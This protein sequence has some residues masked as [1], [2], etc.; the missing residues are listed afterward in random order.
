M[1]EEIFTDRSG[2]FRFSQLAPGDY[3]VRVRKSGYVDVERRIDLQ[4]VSSDF[5]FV[6][7]AADKAARS[8]RPS[9][10]VAPLVLDASVPAPARE[11]FERGREMVL[12]G[13]VEQGLPALEKAVV[14]HP[15]F[16]DA[17]LLLGT[18]YMDL[19]RWEQA[20]RSL[21]SARAVK[22]GAAPPLF[23]LGEVY[24]RQ[25]KYEEAERVLQEGLK[26]DDKS[27]QG[28]L[29]LGRVY[30][31]QND[32]AKAGPSVGR[33]LKLKPDYAEAHLLAGNILLRARRPENALVEFEEY[34]RL[35]PQGE[36]AAQARN[37]ADRIRKALAE[38]KK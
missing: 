38:Q 19:G 12:A 37:A 26:L 15:K 32:L 22:A 11:Y 29:A 4:R 2:R 30:W 36:F 8:A 7:L 9:S 28:H 13:K 31:E 14:L 5:V 24:R 34:L 27:P 35:A 20:E 21:Q 6:Q 1:V 18:A 10:P 23:A 16:F 3:T 17:H 25:K 33:A